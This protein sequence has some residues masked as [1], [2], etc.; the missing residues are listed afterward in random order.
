MKLLGE[1]IGENLYDPGLGK[2]FI[3][4]TAKVRPKREKI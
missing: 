4:K 3:D 1:T 2:D